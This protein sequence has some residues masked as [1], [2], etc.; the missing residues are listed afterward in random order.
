[1][2]NL[3][4][5]SGSAWT[6]VPDGVDVSYRSSGGAWVNPVTLNHYSG[7][8]WTTDWSKS[9]EV[10][11]GFHPVSMRSW[12]T[13]GWK[14]T[15]EDFVGSYGYGDHWCMLDFTSSVDSTYGVTLAAAL[16]IR[17]VVKAAT[18]GFS[19]TG[20]GYGTINNGGYYIGYNTGGYGSGT[21]SMAS[22]HQTFHDLTSAG[23]VQ[24]TPRNFTGLGDL[25][26]DLPNYQL[27][28]AN[29]LSPTYPGGSDTDYTNVNSSLTSHTLWVRLDYI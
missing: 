8:S 13:S 27:T 15:G 21:P 20:G 24:N 4:R 17:P 7:S 10:L 26:L 9:D 19:R 14:P 29:T 11:Y 16:A 1:M 18:L 12:R 6:V 22:T 5:Y 2:S 28:V 3:Y 25:A 23:W